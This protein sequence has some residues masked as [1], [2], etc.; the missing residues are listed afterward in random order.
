MNKQKITEELAEVGAAWA[1][2]SEKIVLPGDGFGA[3]A[4]YHVHPDA[5][6]PHQ[7]S[8]KRFD[9]LREVAAYVD[10]RKKAKAATNF[11]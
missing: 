3:G 10:A 9:N 4:T 11:E 6:Y 7:Y 1:V 2:S 5:S 8:I